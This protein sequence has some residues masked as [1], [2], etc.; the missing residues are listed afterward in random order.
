MTFVLNS[1]VTGQLTYSVDDVVV[2]RA[3]ERQPLTLD[4]YNGTFNAYVTMTYTG[5]VNPAQNGDRTK[6]VNMTIAQN[7]TSMSQ[8][9][10]TGPTTCVHNG[11]YVQY[12]RSGSFNST[13][14]CSDGSTTAMSVYRMSNQPY[15]F[16]ARYRADSSSTGCHEDGEIVGVVPR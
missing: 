7:G 14:S 13:G 5:C 10:A 12:G 2:A 6:A 4:D 9:W 1:T 15:A 11:T 3:V 16:M 8:I